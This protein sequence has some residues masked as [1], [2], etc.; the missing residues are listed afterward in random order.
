MLI[1]RSAVTV[2][3][4]FNCSTLA[5]SHRAPSRVCRTS[6]L[7]SLR[8]TTRA[9]NAHSRAWSM[10]MSCLLSASS[11]SSQSKRTS[12]SRSIWMTTDC[13]EAFNPDMVFAKHLA[14]TIY[15]H[16]HFSVHIACPA[17]CAR[18]RLFLH[19]LTFILSVSCVGHMGEPCTNGWT[20][21]CAVWG[22]TR[23][24]KWPCISWGY[25][26]ALPDEYGWM[27]HAQQQCKLRQW[28]SITIQPTPNKFGRATVWLTV[29]FLD[30]LY[31][32][33]LRIH[34]VSKKTS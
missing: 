21:R 23:D 2:R 3:H 10:P 33:V 15:W 12:R 30:F 29:C 13:L 6:L 28:F 34:C 1:A 26:W 32:F 11:I 27:I 20:G 14:E 22:Q 31:S 4:H 25:I 9:S 17:G 5:A 16:S 24:R 18:S 19:V 7:C 8:T